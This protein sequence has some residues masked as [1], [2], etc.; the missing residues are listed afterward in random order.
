MDVE[1]W[2]FQGRRWRVRLHE[3]GGKRHET[4]AHY[5]LENTWQP[6]WRPQANKA[7][8]TLPC[9]GRLNDRRY[10]R[11]EVYL[12][13]RRRAAGIRTKIGNHTFR[14]AGIAA[15][16]KNGGKLQV[17]RQT[18]ARGSAQTTGLRSPRG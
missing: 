10:R 11:P 8:R 14:A 1:D 7:T 2:Y 15:Y 12:T 3:K 5:N 9:S 4:P 6:A 17:A 13:V 16:L 18:T